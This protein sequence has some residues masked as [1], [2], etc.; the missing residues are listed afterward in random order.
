MMLAPGRFIPGAL[1]DELLQGLVGIGDIEFQTS[2][3]AVGH[4]LD[5]LAFAIGEQAVEVDATPTGLPWAVEVGAE[6]FRVVVEP[7]E[8]VR[9]LFRGV[10]S[11]HT[12]CTD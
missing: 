11:V 4:R 12:R 6:V 9:R 1:V 8:D 5:A 3:E 2:G 10:S 7:V